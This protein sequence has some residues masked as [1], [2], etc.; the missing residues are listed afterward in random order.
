MDLRSPTMEGKPIAGLSWTGCV[1]HAR[2]LTRV[3]ALGYGAGPFICHHT[4][5][6]DA[7]RIPPASARLTTGLGFPGNRRSIPNE[8]LGSEALESEALESEASVADAGAAL[9]AG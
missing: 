1:H 4:A 2:S 7:A 9:L 6:V 8:A 3:G 5:P